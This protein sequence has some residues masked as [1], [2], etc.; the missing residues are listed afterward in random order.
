MTAKRLRQGVKETLNINVV[1]TIF[2]ALLK[3]VTSLD[4][5]VAFLHGFLPLEGGLG[6]ELYIHCIHIMHT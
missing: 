2:K 4:S 3:K 6:T 1:G 5:Q